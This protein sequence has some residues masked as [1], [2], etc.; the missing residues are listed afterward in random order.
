MVDLATL[1]RWYIRKGIE[2]S[3]PSLSAQRDNQLL[4]SVCPFSFSLGSLA[5]LI[6]RGID[7]NLSLAVSARDEVAHRWLKA[8]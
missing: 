1:E 4:E 5:Q 7:Y 6:S 3:N 8:C 2:G